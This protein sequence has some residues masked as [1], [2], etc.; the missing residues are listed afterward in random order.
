MLGVFLRAMLSGWDRWFTGGLAAV[1]MASLVFLSAGCGAG[2]ALRAASTQ[3]SQSSPLVPIPHAVPATAEPR[4]LQP[5]DATIRARSGRVPA[6]STS[7]STSA[8]SAVSPPARSSGVRATSTR[9]SEAKAQAPQR[10]SS[11]GPALQGGAQ[12]TT[13]PT[14]TTQ[15]TPAAGHA[16]PEATQST[17]AE[18]VTTTEA[19]AVT[20]PHAT[21]PSE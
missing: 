6:P 16:H 7:V 1:S 21:P 5:L 3:T 15:P 17:Q 14:K 4:A 12:T 10:Q 9:A 8:S 11:E 13:A 2:R 19:P 20:V 18:T